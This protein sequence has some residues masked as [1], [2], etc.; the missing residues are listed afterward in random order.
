MK[1]KLVAMF[2]VLV[3]GFSGTAY[4]ASNSDFTQTIN[5]GVL[6]TDI[7]DASRVSVASP[8]VAMSAVTTS[9]D[10][11]YVGSGAST[12]TFGSNT[13]R[14]YVSNPAAANNG[15]TLSVA[16][17]AGA[18]A[19]WDDGGTNSFDFNDPTGTNAGCT[20]GADTDALGGQLG[21]DPNAGT[22]TTDCQSC[23][24]TGVT[25]GSAASFDEGTTDS[26]TLINAASGSDDVWRGYLTDAG[27]DQTIPAET[28]AANYSINLTL[29]SVAN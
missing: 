25:K 4:A 20:D 3:L 18:T 26:I 16:A 11:Q 23:S 13:E 15:W 2:S 7:L 29:T 6:L 5:A 19:T 17:T 14:V 10:C 28:P 1:H 27:V 9:F 22:I 21:L 24:S 12:G 8:S